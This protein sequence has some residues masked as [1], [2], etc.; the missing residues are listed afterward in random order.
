MTGA[1]TTVAI[2]IL[3]T[4][5]IPAVTIFFLREEQ[6]T[7]RTVINLA[8]AL[9]KVGLVIALIPPVV[10]GG[11]IEWRYGLLPGIDFVLRVEPFALYFLGLSAFLWLLTTIYAI[12]YLEDGP[13]RSRFFAFFSLSVAAT[14][15]AALSG[16]FITFLIFYELLTLATYPLVAHHQTKKA[17]GGART[18]LMFTV[19]GGTVL[20]F[21]VVWLTYLAGP[22][23]FRE[24]GSPAVAA[25]AADRPELATVVFVLLL[26]GLGVKAALFGLH[27]W[28]P[29]AMVAPAPVSALLHAVAVV[30]VG[31]FGIV[32]LVDDVYGVYVADELGLL[33]PLAILACVTILYGSVQAL[34]QDNFKRRLAY[35]TVS[36]VS[37]V[38]LGVSLVS[39][40]ATTGGVAHII[41]Q[42][43]MKITMFFV[44][45]LLAERLGVETVSRMDGVGRRMP[46]ACAAFTVAALGM[47]GIPPM[48][49]FLSKWYLGVGAIDSGDGW[50]VAVLIASSLLNGAYFLPIVYRMWWKDPPPD[51]DWYQPGFRYR[52][53]T[54]A[55]AALLMPPLV[56]AGAVIAVGVFAGLSYSPLELARFIVE[57]AYGR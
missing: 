11:R 46:L 9:I 21:G 54:E 49:G 8:G 7:A 17:F 3:F 56:T 20:L 1:M 47:I 40:L 31:V 22:V 28:L 51:A 57:G 5:L 13:N 30:K 15:G 19:T 39:V 34:R 10:A 55:P 32:L 14:S 45:G 42:G 6:Q 33:T 25:L 4:S 50:V 29:R 44:A 43:L 18:Y 2:A 37:Y 38:V 23:E 52:V 35:S 48:A 12:G 27:A 53:R 24:A 41:N 16:N 26:A 36:Q